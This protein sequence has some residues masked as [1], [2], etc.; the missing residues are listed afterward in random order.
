MPDAT[1]DATRGTTQGVTQDATQGATSGDP[2]AGPLRPAAMVLPCVLPRRPLPCVVTCAN[3]PGP[4]RLT[5]A[6]QHP[7]LRGRA[8][9]GGPA[10]RSRRPRAGG[11][12]SARSTR[13]A[14]RRTRA[15]P[16]ATSPA[17]PG[18]S[19]PRRSPDSPPVRRDVGELLQQIP[20]GWPQFRF[21]P[22]GAVGNPV[23]P[24]RTDL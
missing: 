19:A 9:S 17:A 1:E 7:W 13:P 23:A 8:G 11:R 14:P 3:L 4:P 15:S 24:Q 22:L 18:R 2:A 12:E 21:V 10:G 20:V 16:W 5:W 6:W